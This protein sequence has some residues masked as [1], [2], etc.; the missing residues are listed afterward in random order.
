MKGPAGV[1]RGWKATI[2]TIAVIAAGLFMPAQSRG[3][4][5]ALLLQQTPLDGGIVT[6]SPGVHFFAPNSEI[7]LTATPNPGYKFIYWLG[8]VGDPTANRTI[9]YLNKPKII[10]A[11]FEPIE[12]STSFIGRGS[13]GGGRVTSDGLIAAADY[14]GWG[15]TRLASSGSRPSGSSTP[16]PYEQVWEPLPWT[17]SQSPISPESS[18]PSEPPI[19]EPATGILL[20]LGSLFLIARKRNRAVILLLFIFCLVPSANAGLFISVNGVIEPPFAEVKLQ[21]DATAVIGIQ[22]DGLTPPPIAL[23]LLVEGP[24]SIDRSTMVY[25]GALS[26][27]QD[28][29]LTVPDIEVPPPPEEQLRAARELL[30]RPD[31]MDLS[32]ITLA[33]SA[34]PPAPLDGLLVDNIILHCDAIGDVRLSLISDDFATVYDTQAIRQVPEPATLFLLGLG[35]LFAVTRRGR[36]GR[37]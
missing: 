7:V 8:D 27:Y 33:D 9:T 19:P 12:D 5:V 34:I 17:P 31:L 6:P 36:K 25:P 18:T 22:G 13:V 37:A 21:P 30:G 35:S 10:I 23:Y 3:R 11:I 32:F 29:P 16:Y 28:F 26:A 15:Q 4:D 14:G 2:V 24:G 20:F 1:L